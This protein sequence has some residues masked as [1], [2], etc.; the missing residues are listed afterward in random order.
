[1]SKRVKNAP[2]TVKLVVGHVRTRAKAMG[3][4]AGGPNLRLGMGKM[5]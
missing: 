4:G 2:G 5:G 1:M 3:K